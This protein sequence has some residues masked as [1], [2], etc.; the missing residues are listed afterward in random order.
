MNPDMVEAQHH[1]S[2]RLTAGFAPPPPK[3]LMRRD[4]TSFGRR[5]P[6][7]NSSR[8]S[9]STR[10]GNADHRI[11]AQRS[12]LASGPAHLEPSRRALDEAKGLAV[13]SLTSV[14][15]AS[16]LIAPHPRSGPIFR[17]WRDCCLSGG[18]ITARQV[19]DPLAL[20][21][22]VPFDRAGGGIQAR[23]AWPPIC[24]QH[25]HAEERRD[26]FVHGGPLLHSQRAIVQESTIPAFVS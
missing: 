15:A 23:G 6:S 16:R 4:A 14:R 3:L 19:I 22:N 1:R 20:G 10:L 8:L 12:S 13:Q 17:A 18:G 25:R 5:G 7:I 21:V 11:W 2:G 9:R 24:H 26:Q